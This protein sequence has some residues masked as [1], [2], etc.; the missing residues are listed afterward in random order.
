MIIGALTYLIKR[1]EIKMPT[2][3]EE[4]IYRT[5]ML[6]YIRYIYRV[7]SQSYSDVVR[8]FTAHPDKKSD[9]T[10]VRVREGRR[11][12]CGRGNLFFIKDIRSYLHIQI[13]KR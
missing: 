5:V 2:S 9:R 8:S 1:F 3:Q 6:C 4:I 7:I 11:C 13:R 12:Q 10:N